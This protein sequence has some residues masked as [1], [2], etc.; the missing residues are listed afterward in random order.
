MGICEC[1]I[2]VDAGGEP[3]TPGGRIDPHHDVTLALADLRSD[4]LRIYA[5][6]WRHS[7]REQV[8]TLIH[9]FTHLILDTFDYDLSGN[10]GRR[11]RANELD[12]LDQLVYGPDRAKDFANNPVTEAKAIT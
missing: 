11:G 9:E 8:V 2:T 10:P 5:S 1:P 4:R 7:R 12:Q 3:R 6:F